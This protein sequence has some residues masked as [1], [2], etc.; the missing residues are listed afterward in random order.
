MASPGWQTE[1]N[2][3]NIFSA[4]LACWE[5]SCHVSAGARE[6]PGRE[7]VGWGKGGRNSGVS[8]AGGCGISSGSVTCRDNVCPCG[9][10]TYLLMK[11]GC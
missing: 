1:Q 11:V 6:V 9:G 3:Q 7:G 8:G 2:P 5:G 10:K 4:C